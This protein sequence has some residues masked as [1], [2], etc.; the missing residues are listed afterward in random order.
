MPFITTRD[1][2][3]LY[4]KDWGSGQPVVLI[5]GCRLEARDDEAHVASRLSP[6]CLGD[7]IT[8]EG[9]F[10]A[11]FHKNFRRGPVGT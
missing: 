11:G 5:H 8:E 9:D 6:T 2:T 1:T 3:Q 7:R 4:V 10:I